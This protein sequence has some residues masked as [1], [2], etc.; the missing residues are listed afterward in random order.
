MS[1]ASVFSVSYRVLSDALIEALGTAKFDSQVR[2]KV[3]PSIK[4]ISLLSNLMIF[5]Y[6]GYTLS[7]T[8]FYLDEETPYGSVAHWAGS[9]EALEVRGLEQLDSSLCSYNASLDYL[10]EIDSIWDYSA[11]ACDLQ[12]VDKVAYKSGQEMHFITH[13]QRRSLVTYPKVG[14]SC[15]E[16]CQMV[17]PAWPSN[18]SYGGRKWMSVHVDTDLFNATKSRHP[19]LPDVPNVKMHSPIDLGSKCRCISFEN[20]YNPG[21][22]KL[23]LEFTHEYTAVQ[24]KM[25]GSS[26]K[27]G[28]QDPQEL[29]HQRREGHL[30]GV[31]QG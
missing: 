13:E 4:I 22:E 7:V 16:E 26:G 27:T 30:E 29:L 15:D 2:I 21:V 23:T 28:V 25:E 6:I 12:S 18:A 14:S 31:C 1:S 5:V 11:V 8:N 20:V 19:A 24:A 3:G 17:Y 10:W 9:D